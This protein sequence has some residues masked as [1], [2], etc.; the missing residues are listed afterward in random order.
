MDSLSFHLVQ[1]VPVRSVLGQRWVHLRELY[2][3]IVSS[4]LFDG[5]QRRELYALL[6][7]HFEDFSN[8]E[9]MATLEA[10]QNLPIPKDDDANRR[11]ERVQ[12]RW[13]GAITGTTYEP[14]AEWLAELTHEY[15]SPPEHPDGLSVIESR[16]GPGPSQYSVQELVALA[17]EG[18]IVEILLAFKPSDA[19]GALTIEGLVDELEHAVEAAPTRFVGVLPDFLKAPRQYQYGLVN[20]FLKL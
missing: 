18:S 8:E 6:R 5:G 10:I 14:A 13:L 12:H 20:G 3:T 15:G 19:W 7:N 11:L 4:D 16:W 1:K 9:K 17:E 2:L